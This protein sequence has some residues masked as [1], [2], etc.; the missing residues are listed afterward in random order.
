VGAQRVA[1]HV[2]QPGTIGRKR[3]R[4]PWRC[5]LISA[6]TFVNSPSMAAERETTKLLAPAAET[7]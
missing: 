7:E 6:V 5:T 2:N 4:S 3:A 1:A